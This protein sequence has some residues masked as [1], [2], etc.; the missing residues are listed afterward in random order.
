MYIRAIDLGPQ[1]VEPSDHLT[2]G[3]MKPVLPPQRNHGNVRGYCTEKGG[4]AGCSA[5]VVG[6]EKNG[7]VKGG[8]PGLHQRFLRLGHDVSGEK[9]GNVFVCQPDDDG[10]V[11]GVPPGTGGG[12]RGNGRRGRENIHVHA[13]YDSMPVH[14]WEGAYGD[15]FSLDGLLKF[16]VTVGVFGLS[17]GD[18][19]LDCEV[20]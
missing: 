20:L 10:G 2:R 3:K 1:F 15:I 12:R 4:R 14:V 7:A 17:R 13:V 18:Q 5:A 9:E 16:S 8:S 19:G 6:D 11:V